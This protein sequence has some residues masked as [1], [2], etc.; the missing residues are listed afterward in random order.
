MLQL[1]TI[2]TG[3]YPLTLEGY[4]LQI[5]QTGIM[6]SEMDKKVGMLQL[7]RVIL[8][9]SGWALCASVLVYGA[10]NWAE[11]RNLMY[12]ATNLIK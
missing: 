9:S 4:C 10:A 3:K 11:C 1:P 2:H 5:A 7:S 8:V 12:W 6:E